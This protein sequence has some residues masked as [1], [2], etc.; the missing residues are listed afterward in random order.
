M[1]TWAILTG[2]TKTK[3]R[4]SLILVPKP[5]FEEHQ[6]KHTSLTVEGE[7]SFAK[8]ERNLTPLHFCLPFVKNE[9]ALSV[10]F[11]FLFTSV[12]RGATPP[13]ATG[14]VYVVCMW[15]DYVN[16]WYIF[17]L[18]ISMEHNPHGTMK[19]LKILDLPSR[20]D[21]FACCLFSPH[22]VCCAF[23]FG[24]KKKKS[25]YIHVLQLLFNSDILARL[26]K[27]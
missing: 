19:C 13:Q 21:L 2:W 7:M 16:N 4:L 26:K 23:E 11:T 14:S 12:V 20:G 8:D 10:F 9:V 3:T 6:N 1:L 27:K 25:T 22:F 5:N 24:K 18:Y 17:V 15:G